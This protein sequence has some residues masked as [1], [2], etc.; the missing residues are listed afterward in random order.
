MN[1]KLAA[2]V[3]MLTCV[4]P[5]RAAGPATVPT[6]QSGRAVEICFVLD[7]TSSM[8]GL[9]DGAKRKI[10]S[11][12]ND[13]ITGRPR[14]TSIR[15]AMV[16]FRDK[17]DAYVTQVFDLTDDVDTVYKNLQ[18]LK[19]EGGGDTP[20]SVNAALDTAV[21]KVA[22]SK[23]TDVYKVVFLVGDAPPHMDYADDLKYPAVCEKAVRRGLVVNAVQC[24]TIAETT[25]VWQD[26]ARRGEGAFIQLG[27]GGD[28][29][30]AVATPMDAELA[31]LNRQ[32]GR[33]LVPFGV[34]GALRKG[35]AEAQAAK[36]SLSEAA[37]AA[38]RA[39]RLNYNANSGRAV[40][41]DDELIDAIADGRVKL[42]DLKDDQLPADWRPLS[43]ADRE[44]KVKQLTSDRAAIRTKIA[45]ASK[46][47]DA[48]LA[49]ARQRQAKADG[50]SFDGRVTAI[51]AEQAARPRRK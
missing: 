42:A 9:I 19:A 11:I 29:A 12:A 27:Q 20:E 28:M 4:A 13:V 17:G 3:L 18:T 24:G 40:Q 26:V 44:A 36:Q 22:W 35:A 39:D 43:A 51:V 8:T 48:Y 5:L 1:V 10:W 49:D 41:G 37:S 30:E 32:V 31:D 6:T 50:D 14:P 7:T 15:I 45:D 23:D 16:A 46:R 34:G 33:T 47:R 25:P 2:S 21:E 38:A